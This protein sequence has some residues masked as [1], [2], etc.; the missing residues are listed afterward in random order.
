ME[1][2][3]LNFGAIQQLW[4]QIDQLCIRRRRQIGA[5]PKSQRPNANLIA[6]TK[7]LSS[8]DALAVYKCAGSASRIGNVKAAAILADPGVNFG[9]RRIL[10]ADR[11]DRKAANQNAPRKL[12]G[13]AVTTKFHQKGRHA[14]NHLAAV[15][16]FS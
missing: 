13:A 8:R 3:S 4:S 11:V 16:R 6:I 9:Y 7:G 15:G 2:A 1:H 10:D 5:D 14:S 12:A